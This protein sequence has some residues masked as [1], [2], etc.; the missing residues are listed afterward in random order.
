MLV[1]MDSWTQAYVEQLVGGARALAG[2]AEIADFSVPHWLQWAPTSFA[3][4]QILASIYVFVQAMDSLG[5]GLA[6]FR[7]PTL[8]RI[9]QRVFPR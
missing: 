1:A 2:G 7:R 5:E 8:A 9:W 6:R 4:L 3:Q